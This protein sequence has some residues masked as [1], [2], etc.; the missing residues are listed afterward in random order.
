M[1]DSGS[2]ED[3]GIAFRSEGYIGRRTIFTTGY[4]IATGYGMD[5]MEMHGVR[6]TR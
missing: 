2:W 3:L 5:R 6:A 4:H 1:G